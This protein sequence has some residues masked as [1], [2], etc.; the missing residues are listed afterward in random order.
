MGRADEGDALGGDGEGSAGHGEADEGGRQRFRFSVSVRMGLVG[1]AHGD[2][3][4]DV[5]DSGAEDIGEGFDAVGNEGERVA[6]EA[7]EALGQRQKKIGNNA[8][9]RGAEAAVDVH[10]GFG[11]VGHRGE[12]FSIL[13]HLRL[14]LTATCGG[15]NRR[16]AALC[17][18]DQPSF[19]CGFE[20]WLG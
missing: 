14:R 4:P 8:E 17:G 10:L 19:M 9:E 15:A 13:R 5:N 7:G 3:Q 16:C 12:R 1:W 18:R 6:D 2:A 11:G 20:E